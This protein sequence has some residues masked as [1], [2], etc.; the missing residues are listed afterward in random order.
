MSGEGCWSS[1]TVRF[2]RGDWLPLAPQLVDRFWDRLSGFRCGWPIF[3]S[4]NTQYH[5]HPPCAEKES[6]IEVE[7]RQQSD[8][9]LIYKDPGWPFN[10]QCEHLHVHCIQTLVLFLFHTKKYCT[11]NDSV[12]IEKLDSFCVMLIRFQSESSAEGFRPRQSWRTEESQIALKG[13]LVHKG[14]DKTYPV[15]AVRS[16]KSGNVYKK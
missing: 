5:I 15:L 9:S 1:L 7:W 6:E 8:L 14:A 3:T 16:I 4:G 12:L 10:T 13:G 11:I 2:G